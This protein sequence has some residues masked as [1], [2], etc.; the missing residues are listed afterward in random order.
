MESPHN[1]AVDGDVD[2]YACE[3]QRS[4]DTERM[5]SLFGFQ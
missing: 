2:R 1:K 4:N 3:I 5:S